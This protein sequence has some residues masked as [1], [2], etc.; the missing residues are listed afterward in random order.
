MALKHTLSMAGGMGLLLAGRKILGVGLFGVGIAGLEREWRERH[1]ELPPGLDVRW[2]AA[3]DHY[4]ATH[5]QPTNRTLHVVGI[6]MILG[7]AFGLLISAPPRPTWLAGA[8]LFSVGWALNLIGHA[9][10]EKNAPAF[11]DDPL[12][13]LAGPVWDLQQLLARRAGRGPKLRVVSESAA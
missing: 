3:L 9:A 8:A 11:K 2:Q 1:P 4:E 6:P 12:S 13:F 7:G 5:Q 10:F